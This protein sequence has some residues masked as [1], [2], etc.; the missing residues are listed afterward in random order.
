M[1][2]ENN[3]YVAISHI[4]TDHFHLHI[5]T[6][7]V[8][9][10]GK[11]VSDSQN[12]K[13][14]AQYCRKMELKYH[15]KQVLSPKKYLSQEQRNTARFHTRKK[16]LKADIKLCLSTSKDYSQFE[17]KIRQ[18]GYEIIKGRGITFMDNKQ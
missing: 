17:N 1:G 7:R 5:V 13:K 2:F 11:V 4:D 14:I 12:Y 3:Q 18:Q 10:N 8:G 9:Y 15:L 6:N 16:K